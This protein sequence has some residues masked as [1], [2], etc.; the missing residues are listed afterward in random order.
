MIPSH[1][2]PSV[3]MCDDSSFF[4]NIRKTHTITSLKRKSK[5]PSDLNAKQ[6]VY[7]VNNFRPLAGIKVMYSTPH[8]AC[9]YAG[10]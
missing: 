2:E 9:I 10:L 1:N 8:E 7:K 3:F 5:I 6:N 4:C